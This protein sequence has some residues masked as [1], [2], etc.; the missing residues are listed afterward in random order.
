MILNI[1]YIFIITTFIFFFYM[2]SYFLQK[3]NEDI[4]KRFD[5]NTLNKIRKG[6]LNHL[7]IKGKINTE[8]PKIELRDL[9]KKLNDIINDDTINNNNIELQNKI[10]ETK[11]LVEKNVILE[12]KIGKIKK[13]I[14]KFTNSSIVNI[15]SRNRILQQK[16]KNDLENLYF[17]VYDPYKLL[18]IPDN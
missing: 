10:Q 11:E 6:M 7:F 14:F 16:E 12:E 8:T 1:L 4:A 9:E 3:P 13:E 15:N 18:I 17:N 2:L 5:E